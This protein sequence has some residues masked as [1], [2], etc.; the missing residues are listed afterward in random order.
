MNYIDNESFVKTDD[1]IRLIK[2]YDN[3]NFFKANF[4]K[5]E[6][7][8]FADIFHFE[9]SKVELLKKSYRTSNS[10][11]SVPITIIEQILF[12]LARSLLVKKNMIYFTS[13][14][15]LLHLLKNFHYLCISLLILIKKN[16]TKPEILNRIQ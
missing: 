4:N 10:L 1:F 8:I 2:T 11:E 7:S 15:R 13:F 12:L 14:V 3:L 5:S 16:F 6:I 9:L